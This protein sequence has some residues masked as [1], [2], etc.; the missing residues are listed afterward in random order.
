MAIRNFLLWWKTRINSAENKVG[1]LNE[2]YA[3]FPD[4]KF[5]NKS[6]KILK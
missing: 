2:F 6:V 1:I 4:G 3:W 5:L